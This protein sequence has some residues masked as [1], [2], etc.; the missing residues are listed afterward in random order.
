MPSKTFPVLV[1]LVV[2]L[3][4]GLVYWGKKANT[5]TSEASIILFVGNG[6]PHCENVEAYVDAND[7][8]SVVSYETREVFDDQKNAGLMQR[9][10]ATCASGERITGVPFLW[11]D[12]GATCL[13]G[14]VD[15][16]KFFKEKAGK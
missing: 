3:L 2:V 8:A 16:I 6:C 9:K 13:V 1:L 4:I 5:A 15:I 7:I 11:A 12:N 14:D 10:A